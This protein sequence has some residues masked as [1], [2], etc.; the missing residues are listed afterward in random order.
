MSAFMSHILLFILK[1]LTE[2]KEHET[3]GKIHAG[4]YVVKDVG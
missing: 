2:D 3:K 4:G 1:H